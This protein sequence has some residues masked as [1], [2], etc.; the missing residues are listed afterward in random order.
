MVIG[1]VA[2]SAVLLDWM[3]RDEREAL[4]ETRGEHGAPGS[5]P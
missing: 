5:F 3:D 2:L 1:T 4:L